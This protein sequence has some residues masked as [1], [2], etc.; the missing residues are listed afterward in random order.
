MFSFRKFITVSDEFSKS[1]HSMKFYFDKKIPNSTILSERE[2]NY[3]SIKS[4]RNV[5]WTIAPAGI[6]IWIE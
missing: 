5:F 1:M 3:S 6:E 4:N 2:M